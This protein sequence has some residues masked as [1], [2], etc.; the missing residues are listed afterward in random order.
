MACALRPLNLIVGLFADNALVGHI[1][2]KSR[3]A[4]LSSICTALLTSF[5][6]MPAFA[7]VRGI[8]SPGSTLT[9]GG[10]LPD[11]SLSYSNQ[12][13]YGF[14]NDLKGEH[15]NTIPVQSSVTVLIAQ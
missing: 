9:D 4:A 1:P 12:F 2:S 10:T 6:A 7:Q 14:S 11:P 3:I 8:Y 5:L 13:W 15:G